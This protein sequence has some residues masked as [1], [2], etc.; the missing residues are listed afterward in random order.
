VGLKKREKTIKARTIAATVGERRKKPGF[1]HGLPRPHIVEL[2][3]RRKKK[4]STKEKRKSVTKPNLKMA[5]KE[6]R[7][8]QTEM[9]VIGERGRMAKGR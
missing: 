6:G 5:Y 2:L 9:G 3:G 1:P 4:D 7:K 8:R